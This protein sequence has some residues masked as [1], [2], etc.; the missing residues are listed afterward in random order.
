M[1]FKAKGE[2]LRSEFKILVYEYMISTS[3][4]QADNSSM[5]QS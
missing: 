5:K 4:C 3:K 2:E 1:N